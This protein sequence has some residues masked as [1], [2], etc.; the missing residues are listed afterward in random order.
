MPESISTMKDLIIKVQKVLVDN[1][2]N[3]PSI[4][5][6]KRGVLPPTPVFPAVSILPTQESYVYQ[7][8]GGK[9]KV[10]REM[11]IQIVTKT[12]K[13]RDGRDQIQDLLDG[14]RTIIIANPTMEDECYDVY[15]ESYDLE[16]PIMRGKEILSI[17]SA[18]INC[19]GIEYKPSRRSRTQK[20]YQAS[21]THLLSKI[22][23]L[24]FNYK[25]DPDYPLRQ[26]K[27]FNVQQMPPQVIFPSAVLSE[28][29][30]ERNRDLV[31][32]DLLNKQINIEVFTKLLDKD[33]AL[34][35][36]LDICENIKRILQMDS[37]LGGAALDSEVTQIYY[38]RSKDDILGLLYNSIITFN[39][40]TLEH[41]IEEEIINEDNSKSW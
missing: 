20:L 13:K 4:K 16:D 30:A 19:I 34:Y 21:S 15:F 35:S 38:R 37:T 9:Y 27:S 31:G 28:G 26:L 17:G 11:E 12:L 22:Y 32:I 41:L 10:N 5:T 23:D 3:I 14:I 25:E 2:A 40:S 24:F 39:C 6:F 1:K 18:K 29:S 33:F 7:Y 8:S 36:N